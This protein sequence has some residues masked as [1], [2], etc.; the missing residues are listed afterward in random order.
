[1]NRAI[2][3]DRDGTIIKK[4]PEGAYWTSA[5]QIELL[6][7]VD[8]AVKTFNDH[9]YKVIVATNQRGVAKGLISPE[10]LFMMHR[11]IYD[12]LKE[13]NA[14]IDDFFTCPHEENICE[15]RK[16]KPGLL[17]QAAKAYDIDLKNSWMIGDTENDILAGKA[18]GCK[19][20]Y[21]G[22]PIHPDGIFADYRAVDLYEASIFITEGTYPRVFTLKTLNRH[23]S[24]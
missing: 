19:T 15:C 22:S 23:K 1:M 18:A 8:Y 7:L 14:I 17:L 10:T 4:P 16:P 24:K 2:F 6:P 3:L 20:A 13:R 5:D 21:I 9:G 11:K 12:T